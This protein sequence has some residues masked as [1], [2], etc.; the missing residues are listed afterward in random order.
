MNR[1]KNVLITGGAGFIGANL[2]RKLHTCKS[3][4]KIFVIDDLSK[5]TY[6]NIPNYVNFITGDVRNY[7]LALSATKLADTV[8]H[9]AAESGVPS[10]IENPIKSVSV[11]VDGTLNFL[12]ASRINGV[13]KFI[14]SSSGGTILGDQEPPVTEKSH[15]NP[16]SPY[17]AGKASAEHLINS[18]NKSFGLNTTIFRFSNVY[19]PYSLHK[20]GNFV[21]EF[22]NCFVN[23]NTFKIYGD[24]T[25]TRD[26]VYVDDL[27]NALYK[28]MT[29]NESNGETFQVAYGKELTING[30]VNIMNTILN[31]EFNKQVNIEYLPKRKGD[32]ERNYA[33]INKIQDYLGW[34][35]MY[36]FQL[37]FLRMIKSINI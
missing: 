12:E 22:L 2:I 37:G 10:S 26:F 25:Q 31:I 23:G 11:N 9:F 27:V 30:A 34:V 17:G 3:I 13:K 16:I 21:P 8:F 7:D 32:V 33:K 28:G 6:K 24:G 18:Y 1:E 19:G 35:P 5:G 15:F 36:N 20:T 29:M 14:F 4:E